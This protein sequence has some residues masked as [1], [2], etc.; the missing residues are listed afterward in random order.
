V[1]QAGAYTIT[2]NGDTSA[3][4]YALVESRLHAQL[5]QPA[6][7][8]T[9]YIGQPL[10][11]EAELFNNTTPVLPRPDEATLVAH[12]TVQ[13]N[14]Q[15]GFSTD[16]ELV[17]QNN[18]AI[19]SRQ[20]TLPAPA[21][22][23]TIEIKAVYLQI[24]VEASQAHVTIPLE[25]AVPPPPVHPC[26][27][28]CYIQR[29]AMALEIGIPLLLMLL[30]LLF[31]LTRKGPY[32][33]LKQGRTEEPL[34]QMRRPFFGK[35][36]HKPT[37]SSRVLENY[38]GFQFNGTQFD[39]VFSGGSVRIRTKSDTPKISVRKGNQSELVTPGSRQGVD[40]ANGDSI[41]VERCVPATFIDSAVE[42]SLDSPGKVRS[43]SR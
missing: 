38:G 16:V 28:T 41:Q 31:L 5:L 22:Q 11:I 12:V 27:I 23:V 9:A 1:N 43:S 17:Q 2:T 6:S 35:L 36:F 20:I 40:L 32:G 7:Q 26:S 3:Q 30:V 25:K 10:Q 24:P 29:Y 39:L 33:S 8:I 37:L 21:G 13:S 34:G 4:V 42:D 14:G 15:T 18:T 19:F